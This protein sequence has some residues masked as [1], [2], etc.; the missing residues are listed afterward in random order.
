[1]LSTIEIE[2]K[3]NV[4]GHAALLRL[5]HGLHALGGRSDRRKEATRPAA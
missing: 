5:A 2:K 3:R 4:S 1:M